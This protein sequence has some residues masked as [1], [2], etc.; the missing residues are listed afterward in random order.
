MKKHNI[1]EELYYQIKNLAFCGYYSREDI[2]ENLDEDIKDFYEGDESNIPSES[3]VKEVLDEIFEEVEKREDLNNFKRIA[4]VFDI[5]SREKIITIHN[6]GYTKEESFEDVNEIYGM[7]KSKNIIPSGAVFYDFAG[8]EKALDTDIKVLPISFVHFSNEKQETLKIGERVWNLL[9]EEG[10]DVEW[11][12][13]I[14]KKIEIQNFE[15]DKKYDLDYGY[16]RTVDIM[17]EK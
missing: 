16:T 6:A 15:Y 4:K 13:E 5:L 3:Q 10:F 8:I 9:K 2:E 12:R 11:S 7:L 17:D 1:D 14:N